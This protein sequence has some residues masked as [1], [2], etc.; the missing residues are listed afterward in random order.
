MR[1]REAL[2]ALTASAGLA[3]LVSCAALPIPHEV[4]LR[5]QMSETEGAV[6]VPIGEGEA[7][8]LDMRLPS[9]DGMCLDFS[10]TAP[11]ATV[12]SAQLHWVID[13]TYEG[14]DLTGK[15]QARAYAAGAGADVFLSQHTIGP[16]VTIKLDRTAT[17][18]AGTAV[19][20]PTQLEAINDREICWGVWVQGEDV[21][22]L[23]DGDA[24]IRYEV[25]QLRL[26][27]T[28]SVI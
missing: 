27:V 20:N 26:R 25:E 28:F 8:T 4:D 5:Q 3:A 18:L 12:Q 10:G 11:G 17:R 23:E 14:P 21:A 22:A 9:E 16:V 19:L 7:E 13:A 24:T 1:L 15:L 2:V 6:T